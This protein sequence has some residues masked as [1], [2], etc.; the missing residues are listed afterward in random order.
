MTRSRIAVLVLVAAALGYQTAGV[1]V[2]QQPQAPPAFRAN[3]LLVPVDVRVVDGDGNP[4]TDLTAADFTLFENGV[5]QQIAHFSTQAYF[6]GSPPAPTPRTFFFLLGRGRLNL[7]AHALDATI[8]FVRSQLRPEDRVG[9]LAYLHL[10]EPTTDHAAVVRLLERYRAQHGAIE[11]K[12]TRDHDRGPGAPSWP[13]LPD[14]QAAIEALFEGLGLPPAQQ[15]PA[16]AGGLGSQFNDGIS[17]MRSLEYLGHVEGEKHLV[18]LIEY[19][20]THGDWYASR[21]EAAR[22]SV[23]TILTGGIQAVRLPSGTFVGTVDPAPT[24]SAVLDAANARSLAEQTGGQSSFYQ[25]PT[26]AFDRLARATSFQYLLGYY[27]IK[28]P[29][30]G[31]YRDLRVTV[32]RR[33]LTLLYRHAY[34]ARPRIDEPLDL[35]AMF[36]KS[37]ILYYATM[38]QTSAPGMVAHANIPMKLSRPVVRADGDT[39]QITTDVRIDARWVT[40]TREGDTYSTSL[41]LAA[42]VR[43]TQEKALGEQ[44]GHVDLKVDASGYARLKRDGIHHTFTV[45]VTGRPSQIVVVVYQYEASRGAWI[46]AKLR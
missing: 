16:G 8:A 2:A 3:V 28:P 29:A 41:D 12:L 34:Q 42:F 30:D 40:F 36:V 32:N 10:V 23:S 14:T 37:R 38:P 20:F 31:E 6:E 39:R 11:D 43:D 9:V 15:F 17:L 25:N 27:P 24:P 35:R 44:W 18:L 5:R 45:N 46:T 7:P 4:V 1:L 13:T 21:A 33:G 26:T 22:V 19:R